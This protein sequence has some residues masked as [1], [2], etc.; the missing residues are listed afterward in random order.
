MNTKTADQ[1]FTSEFQLNK[2]L[3]AVQNRKNTERFDFLKTPRTRTGLFFIT[4][5]PVRYELPDGK[6]L[7]AEKGDV[8]LLP[9]GSHYAVSFDVPDDVTTH[10]IL[11]SFFLSDEAGNEITINQGIA[12]IAHDDGTLLPLLYSAAQFYKNGETA[13]VKARA[14]EIIGRIFPL[15][16]ADRY[17]ISYI[18]RHYA[19][20]FSIPALAKR[21]ALCETAYRK[22][23]RKQTGLSPIQYI[24][25]LKIEKAKEMLENGDVGIENISEF[26]NFYSLPYFYR[27]FKEITGLTP[28]QYRETYKNTP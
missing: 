3:V 18:N 6:I 7:V 2:V 12:K 5:Y 15:E 17:G 1:I 21:C 28:G 22:Q 24:T 8:M 19:E 14:Y 27:V 13:M 26:L 23:F 25:R 10:P 16:E 20:S 4:D 11:L 9:R